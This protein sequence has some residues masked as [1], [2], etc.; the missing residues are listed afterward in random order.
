LKKKKQLNNGIHE[1]KHYSLGGE[2]MNTFR[3]ITVDGEYGFN[4]EASSLDTAR[5]ILEKRMPL[6][7]NKWIVVPFMN[8][9]VK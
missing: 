4:I 5:S 1:Y 2:V 7:F 9:K 3:A 8:G 6:S